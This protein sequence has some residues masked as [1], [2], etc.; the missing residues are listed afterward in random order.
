MEQK[1]PIRKKWVITHRGLEPTNPDFYSESSFDAF[2]N[3]LQRG[4]NIEFDPSLTKDG[5]VVIHDATLKRLT[6]G[7]DERTIANLTTEEL[8]QIPLGDDRIPTLDEVIGLIRTSNSTLNALHLKAHLQTRKALERIVEALFRNSDVFS[9]LIIFDV[10]AKTARKLK[11]RF[12]TLQLAPSVA[13]PYD[14]A[15]Y[16][17]AVGNTLLT[18]EQALALGRE[19]LIDGVWGDEWDTKGENG[20]AKHLYTPE[21]F[22]KLHNARLFVALVTPEL[23]ATSPG[24]YGGESH[25]DARDLPTLFK[26]IK[27]IKDMGAD[28][29]CTDYPEEVL[30]LTHS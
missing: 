28:Y 6:K 13:H 22:E 20:M 9:K 3:H 14:I 11:K 19:G 25:S 10:K 21:F 5:I 2:Q 8:L 12:P 18:I 30:N 24:L 16:N 29:L 27:E 4:F 23:H 15:R 17:R 7:R 1:E 26:Q